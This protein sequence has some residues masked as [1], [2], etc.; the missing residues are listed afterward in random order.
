[1]LVR[2]YDGASGNNRMLGLHFHLTV[3]I[4]EGGGLLIHSDP[5]ALIDLRLFC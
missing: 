2:F 1:V 4:F 5:F 3:G